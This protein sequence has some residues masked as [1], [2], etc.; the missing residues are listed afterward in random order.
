[1]LVYLVTDANINITDI[2]TQI[3]AI[4][5]VVTLSVYEPTHY[6]N[7]RQHIT[8]VRVRFLSLSKNIRINLKLF[9]INLKQIDGVESIVVKIRTADIKNITGRQGKYDTQK[10]KNVESA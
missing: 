3:R 7:D 4:K 6:I 1:M 10:K 5:G 2:L 8:K 9:K